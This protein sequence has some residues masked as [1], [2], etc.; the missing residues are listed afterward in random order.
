[1]KV[2]AFTKF[3]SVFIEEVSLKAFE[4]NKEIA[5]AVTEKAKEVIEEQLFDWTPLTKKYLERKI[6]EGYDPRIYIRSREFL[7]SISW[8]VTHGRVWS[9]V[10]ARKIHEDSGLPM[11]VLA[12][13]HEY[14]APSVG[15][16][17]RPLWR[18]IISMFVRDKPA[19]ARRYRKA[20]NEAVARRTK[21]RS[22]K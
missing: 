12:R 22:K 21:I 1:M 15:I 3:M 2:K 14:G 13:I 10:P 7:M 20:A 17:P 16:P 19:F 4:C 8:G 18:P 9:G 6:T 11:H 5:K